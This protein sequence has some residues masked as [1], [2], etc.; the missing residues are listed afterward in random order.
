MSIYIKGKHYSDYPESAVKALYNFTGPIDLRE[1]N[2]L[3]DFI[4]I[5]TIDLVSNLDVKNYQ[6]VFGN[7]LDSQLLFIYREKDVNDP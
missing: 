6:R 2:D 1:L 4:N 7:Q 5:E 3:I